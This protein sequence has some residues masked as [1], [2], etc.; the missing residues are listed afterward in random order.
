M[1]LIR[2]GFGG[3]SHSRQLMVEAEVV[4]NGDR[5]EC[6]SFPINLNPFLCFNGLM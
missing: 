2:L 4:L 6:L 1:E 5:G 3:A